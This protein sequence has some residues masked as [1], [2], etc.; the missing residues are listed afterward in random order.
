ML[1]ACWVLPI[2]AEQDADGAALDAALQTVVERPA[3]SATGDRF[4]NLP[5]GMDE[6]R[7]RSWGFE[8]E[9]ALYLYV[10]TRA[11]LHRLFHYTAGRYGEADAR[12][13]QRMRRRG[14]NASEA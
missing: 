10:V 6:E 4:I 9:A 13:V 3:Q 7:L 12:A 11:G 5:Q 1:N 2:H 8:R 14:R